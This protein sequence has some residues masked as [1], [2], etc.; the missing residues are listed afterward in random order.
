MDKHQATTIVGLFAAANGAWKVSEATV[1][2]WVEMLDDVPYE[3][4]MAAAR[5][6]VA[7]STE[8]PS[9]ARLRHATADVL[10]LL[11]LETD[12][13]WAAI[14]RGTGAADPFID[15]VVR[16]LGGFR[17][18]LALPEGVASTQFR[19]AYDAARE[20]AVTQVTDVGGLEP[21]PELAAV[22]G[23]QLDAGAAS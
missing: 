2:L 5:R 6:L 23:R 17:S 13:A 16:G 21:R 19:R 18:L 8:W 15:D 9:I 14:R 4:A 10:G 20:R 11:P 7:T 1:G 22:D 12:A 3:P